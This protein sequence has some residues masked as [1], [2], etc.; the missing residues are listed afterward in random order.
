MLVWVYPY[1][2]TIEADKTE[3]QRSGLGVKH[4]AGRQDF[5]VVDEIVDD[6]HGVAVGMR[7]HRLH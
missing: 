3:L 2:N 4:E 6:Q 1:Q 7:G 5:G